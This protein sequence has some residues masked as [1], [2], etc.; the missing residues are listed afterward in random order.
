MPSEGVPDGRGCF[1]EYLYLNACSNTVTQLACPVNSPTLT[2]LPIV[3]HDCVIVCDG[4]VTQMDIKTEIT[5]QNFQDMN[6]K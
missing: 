3:F 1:I 2:D 6:V 4:C 5:C